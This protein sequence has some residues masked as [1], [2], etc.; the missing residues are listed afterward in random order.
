MTTGD[1]ARPRQGSPH[2]CGLNLHS[3]TARWGHSLFAWRLGLQLRGHK[4]AGGSG[5]PASSPLGTWL[6]TPSH[7]HL[8][9]RE[10]EC[11]QLSRGCPA[12]LPLSREP[13]FLAPSGCPR[14]TPCLGLC[15]CVSSHRVAGVTERGVQEPGLQACL[16]LKAPPAPEGPGWPAPLSEA[17]PPSLSPWTPAGAWPRFST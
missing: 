9:R 3:G 1:G 15:I 6:S 11:H 4:Q 16:A 8:C 13:C 17:S 14:R 2:V 7:P 12:P 5:L 10:Y